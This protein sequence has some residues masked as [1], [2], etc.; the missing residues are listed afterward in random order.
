MNEMEQ[1]AERLLE[2]LRVELVDDWRLCLRWSSVRFH[3]VVIA[4]N[5]MFAAMPSLDPQI[6]ALLPKAFQSPAFGIYAA[7]ALA[8]RL[9]KLKASA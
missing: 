6:A 9:T 4:L 1:R 7:I 8:L 3:L 5:A 2:R